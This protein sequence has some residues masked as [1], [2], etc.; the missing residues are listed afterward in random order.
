MQIDAA[1]K[2]LG[3]IGW[4][5]AHTL[6]PPMQNAAIAALGLDWLYAAWPVEPAALPAAI[7]GARALGFIGL[8]VTI[9]HK[10]AVVPLLDDL[11]PEAAAIGAVNMVHFTGG[12][13][14][15]YNTD[16]EGFTRSLA[17]EAGLSLAGRTLLLAGGGG[18]AGAWAAGPPAAGP[19]RVIIAAGRSGRARLLADAIAPHYP[20]TRFEVAG[21]PDAIARAAAA[22]AV[23]ANATPLGMKPGDPLPLPA[24]L[25]EP[26]HV[27]FDAVYRPRVTPLMAAATGRGARVVGGLGML[28]RQGCRALAIWSGRTPDEALMFRTLE[29]LLAAR[30]REAAG[31]A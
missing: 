19:D 6:S 5:I 1:T 21:S 11:S 23:L 22:A 28:V 27:I 30:E 18:A 7:A 20:A 12:R 26:R 4:P 10:E 3:V 24:E 15:G 2:T 16:A 8:N 14:V 13:A 25:I 29:E 31:A 17:E 9:P